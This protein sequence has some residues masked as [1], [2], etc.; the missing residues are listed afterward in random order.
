MKARYRNT[1]LMRQ[2][3]IY[4]RGKY[5]GI[6]FNRRYIRLYKITPEGVMPRYKELRKITGK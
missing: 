5:T 1:G 4:W 3:F 2:V 6:E